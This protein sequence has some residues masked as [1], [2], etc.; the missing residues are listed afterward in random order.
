MQFLYDNI[1]ALGV[2]QKIFA[3]AKIQFDTEMYAVQIR[4]I[5]DYECLLVVSIKPLYPAASHMAP[6]IMYA[7]NHL[8]LIA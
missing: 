5:A 4:K 1:E 2:K 7:I 6:N 3:V 8:A